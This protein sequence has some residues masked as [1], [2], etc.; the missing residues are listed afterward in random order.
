M[1]RATSGRGF[2]HLEK[3]N[4]FAKIKFFKKIVFSVKIIFVFAGAKKGRNIFVNARTKP[5]VAV[6]VLLHLR[7]VRVLL[8]AYSEVH[9]IR[10]AGCISSNSLTNYIHKRQCI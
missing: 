10:L 9:R 3:P 1:P 6:T 7:S 2:Y 4:F 5:S 8:P